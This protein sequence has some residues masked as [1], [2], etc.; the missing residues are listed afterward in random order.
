MA[1]TTTQRVNEWRGRMAIRASYF[2]RLNEAR[3]AKLGF[4]PAD[5]RPEYLAIRRYMEAHPLATCAPIAVEFDTDTGMWAVEFDY[6]GATDADHAVAALAMSD[7]TSAPFYTCA[8]GDGK[9]S[10]FGT[11]EAPGLAERRAEI[12]ELI[13][14][15]LWFRK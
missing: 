3:I 13:E 12:E 6:A 10:W 7:T 9:G 11:N 8:Y 15:G 1:K 4:D 14:A 2:D 5:T